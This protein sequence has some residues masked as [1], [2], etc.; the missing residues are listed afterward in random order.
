MNHYFLPANSAAHQPGSTHRDLPSTAACIKPLTALCVELLIVQKCNC[1][2]TTC[3]TCYKRPSQQKKR[4]TSDELFLH[5]FFIHNVISQSKALRYYR[6]DTN[7]YGQRT[8]RL[9]LLA[10]HATID[11]AREKELNLQRTFSPSFFKSTTRFHTLRPYLGKEGATLT[12]A[13]HNLTGAATSRR[14]IFSSTIGI[15]TT[16]PCLAK[17]GATLRV[18]GHNLT[19]ANLNEIFLHH[20]FI[21]DIPQ[22]TPQ[23][24]CDFAKVNITWPSSDTGFQSIPVM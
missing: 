19:R 22:S 1:P 16:R 8:S 18:A 14:V 11:Q 20:F 4:W 5:Y 23:G 21:P 10:A 13:T 2:G 7:S 12:V 15:H 24:R 9:V 17:E 6:C 3:S